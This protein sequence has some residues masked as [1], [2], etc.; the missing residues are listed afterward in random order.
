MVRAGPARE[1]GG[2][3]A[4]LGGHFSRASE[5]EH[6]TL[7]SPFIHRGL[8]IPGWYHIA[9]NPTELGHMGPWAASRLLLQLKDMRSTVV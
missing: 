6:Q 4:T 1:G 3:G 7:S 5:Q 2:V 9:L 8:V